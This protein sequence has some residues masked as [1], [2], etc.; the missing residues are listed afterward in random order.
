MVEC[1]EM[2]YL[3]SVHAVRAFGKQSG[4]VRLLAHGVLSLHHIS[5]RPPRPSLRCYPVCCALLWNRSIA[6]ASIRL[7]EANVKKRHEA[8]DTAAVTRA[9]RLGVRMHGASRIYQLAC[10]W[11]YFDWH[12]NPRDLLSDPMHRLLWSVSNGN[13]YSFSFVLQPCAIFYSCERFFFIFR[14]CAPVLF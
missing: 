9:V 2:R 5:A 10:L 13:K 14:R 6:E 11:T 8:V 3:S 7:K 4:S 1:F 12:T